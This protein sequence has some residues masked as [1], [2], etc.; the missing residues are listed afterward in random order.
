MAALAAQPDVVATPPEHSFQRL[1]LGPVD[2]RVERHTE[3]TAFTVLAPQTGAPFAQSAV[4]RL[5]AG[6]LEAIPGRILAAVEIASE[7]VPPESAGTAATMECVMELLNRDRLVGGW[8]VER[9]ASVWSTFRLDA[10]GA[11]RILVQGHRLTRAAMAGSCSASS[12]SRPTGWP[13]C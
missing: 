6:W 13:P 7:P 2:L 10:A 8:V 11:T 5:P 3:F 12:K 4:D 1:H 9:V